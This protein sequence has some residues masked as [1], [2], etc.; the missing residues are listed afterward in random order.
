MTPAGSPSPHVLDEWSSWGCNV[1]SQ[2]QQG[3]VSLGCQEDRR[4]GER[5]C[6]VGL[7]LQQPLPS[8][9]VTER[10]AGWQW[11]QERRVSEREVS[12]ELP[13]LLA[14]RGLPVLSW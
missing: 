2:V 10:F 11:H 7:F 12:P 4:W 5:R 13:Q 6:K 3:C 1:R 14:S 8:A 9:V